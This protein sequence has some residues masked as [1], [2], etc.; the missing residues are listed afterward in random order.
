MAILDSNLPLPMAQTLL[1]IGECDRG[2]ES[3]GLYGEYIALDAIENPLGRIAD[4]QPR[5]AVRTRVF[6]TPVAGPRVPST[7]ASWP[8]AGV[9]AWLPGASTSRIFLNCFISFSNGRGLWPY[10]DVRP[11]M[12]P[13]RRHSEGSGPDCTTIPNLR[14]WDMRLSTVMARAGVIGRPAA[15]SA[16]AVQTLHVL[17]R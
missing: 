4:Q 13:L 7:R 9:P 2:D 15:R 14:A 3:L 16:R 11:V 12:N 6:S 5:D 8:R 10:V 1:R 17:N